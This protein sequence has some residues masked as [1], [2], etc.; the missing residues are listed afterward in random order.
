VVQQQ[1]EQSSS[2]ST[3][4]ASSSTAAAAAAA[5]GS[6]AVT[7]AAEAASVADTAGASASATAHS[8]CK[9]AQ[10]EEFNAAD[11]DCDPASDPWLES[12][13]LM[14]FGKDFVERRRK[15]RRMHISS[16]ASNV[17]QK[18]ELNADDT[19]I[20][21]ESDLFESILL[22]AFGKDFVERRR[23]RRLRLGVL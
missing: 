2:P 15:R 1:Q 10:K 9:V 12:I 22:M 18:K 17:A 14:A 16:G 11:E 20:D 5:A 4:S 23:K 7:T 8:A 6:G 19:K 3:S 21:T 13:L